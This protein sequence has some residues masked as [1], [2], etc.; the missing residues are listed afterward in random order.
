MQLHSG[1]KKS[2]QA[3]LGIRGFS[4]YGLLTDY[5]ELLFFQ[6]APTNISVLSEVSVGYKIHHLQMVL[7]AIPDLEILCT[8][9]AEC[10]DANKAFL[11]Q[12]LAQES[13]ER[14]REL[15]RADI[16]MLDELLLEMSSDRQF[17]FL[18]RCRNLKPEQVF[19]TLNRVQ[20]TL[21]GEGFEVRHLEKSDIKRL[22]ALYFD[23]SLYGETIPDIDGA[24]YLTDAAKPV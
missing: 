19:E 22:L 23:A 18:C 11:H 8:D 6:V 24:Q 14:L 15:L 9:A 2:T 20:R 12:R 21:S 5:G 13:N 1:K 16:R 4:R 7:S 3:L 17:F 10:M